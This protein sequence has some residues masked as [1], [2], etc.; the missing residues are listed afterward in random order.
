[1][2]VRTSRVSTALVNLALFTALLAT[3]GCGGGSGPGNGGGGGGGGTG[4]VPTVLAASPGHNTTGV[5]TNANLFATFSTPMNASTVTSSN[6]T[7]SGGVT[8][9]VEYDATHNIAKFNPSGNLAANTSYNATLSTAVKSAGGR[10]LAATYTWTFTTGGGADSAVPT[11]LAG[12]TVP[13]QNATNVALNT[14]IK[15][16]FSE[17]M[18]PTSFPTQLV[19]QQDATHSVTLTVSWNTT[20]DEVSLT[21]PSSGLLAGVYDIQLIGYT[22][23][24]GNTMTPFALHFQ[25]VQP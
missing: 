8:G 23:T 10:S 5:G 1:M 24:C 16:K 21:P 13:A 3:F 25:T 2:W 22:D 9:T 18:D 15:F 11:V 14:V 20:G 6:F 17:P 7:V 19:I 4:P 12:Q